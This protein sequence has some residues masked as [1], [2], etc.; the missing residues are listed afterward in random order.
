MGQ[1]NYY[2]ILYAFLLENANYRSGIPSRLCLCCF[3]A[4]CLCISIAN[5]LIC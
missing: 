4:C 2:E 5:S 1:P 3:G